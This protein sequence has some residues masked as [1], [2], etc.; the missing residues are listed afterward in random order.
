MVVIYCIEDINDLKYVGSTKQTLTTRLSQHRW[1]KYNDN[2]NFC[3]SKKLNLY[4]CIIYPL[5][6]CEQSE[7]KDR[8]RYWINKIECINNYKLNTNKDTYYQDNKE[9]IKNRVKNYRQNNKDL[10][11]EKQKKYRQNNKEYNK[12]YQKQYRLKNKDKLREYKKQYYLKNK[13]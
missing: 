8:E 5:E 11:K 10:I 9:Y 4:N 7:S 1:K 13:K 3:S 2:N 6:E 12:E